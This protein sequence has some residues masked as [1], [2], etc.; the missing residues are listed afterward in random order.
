MH[1]TGVIVRA[2]PQGV[3]K[4]RALLKEIAGLEIHAVCPDGRFVVTIAGDRDDVADALFRVHAL[5]GVLSASMV[6]E[7][8]ETDS[9]QVEASQ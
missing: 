6:Y 2:R 3:P 7:H 9:E 8:S 4:V 1:V 5:E